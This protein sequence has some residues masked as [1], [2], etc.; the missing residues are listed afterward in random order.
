MTSLWEQHN[1]GDRIIQILREVEDE[2]HHFG[3]PFLTAYQLAIE[4]DNR[5]HDIKRLSKS[6]MGESLMFLRN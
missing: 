6:L 1:I 4:F 3:R 2:G 5:H